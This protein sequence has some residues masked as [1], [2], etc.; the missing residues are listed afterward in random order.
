MSSILRLVYLLSLV[1][2]QC[3]S[4]LLFF[5]QTLVKARVVGVK[6]GA[7]YPGWRA[8]LLR[9]EHIYAGDPRL[10]GQT[11][12]AKAELSPGI[13]WP[14]AF[15][16]P[17]TVNEVL[18]D[19]LAK[20]YSF[21]G[22]R[23]TVDFYGADEGMFKGALSL[24][25][26]GGQIWLTGARDVPDPWQPPHEEG[27]VYPKVE[28][29]AK[30]VERVY[31]ADA[32]TRIRLLK[33]DCTSDS[34]LIAA[35][36]IYLLYRYQ[37]YAAPAFLQGLLADGR[38]SLAGQ[39]TADEVL[40][41]LKGKSWSQSSK[42]LALLRA[43]LRPAVLRSPDSEI[44]LGRILWAWRRGDLSS[45]EFIRLAVC[46]SSR[47]PPAD[48]TMLRLVHNETLLKE[49]SC[50]S[51]AIPELLRATQLAETDNARLAA[52]RVL[53]MFCP[54]REKEVAQV[55]PVARN[56]QKKQLRA[57]FE[58][59][60]RAESATEFLPP[61]PSPPVPAPIAP[62]RVSPEALIA[63]AIGAWM[64]GMMFLASRGRRRLLKTQRRLQNGNT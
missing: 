13:S 54:L 28:R 56:A 7:P 18:I 36:A 21:S 44:V 16:P 45:L 6:D 53:S 55:R 40:C 42:R 47:L 51:K 14:A 32:A 52:A 57:L 26:S 58:R 64:S 48:A 37:P 20:Q 11:Y 24:P 31:R 43:W 62:H 27:P 22:W 19:V 2:D 35:W 39:V 3:R 25:S 34:P 46:G 8:A 29:W 4:D 15:I 50:R 5:P 30:E 9:I 12:E 33:E 41:R 61:P 60:M 38:L 49:P 10:V 1:G 17:M 59:I 63:F 23:L